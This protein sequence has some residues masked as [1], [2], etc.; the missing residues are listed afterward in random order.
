MPLVI[1]SIGGTAI[2]GSDLE[3]LNGFPEILNLTV[4]GSQASAVGG[5]HIAQLKGITNFTITDGEGMNSDF[6]Q[7]M[8][9]LESLRFDKAGEDADIENLKDLPKLSFLQ[10]Q[11]AR[12]TDAAL[13]RFRQLPALS[14]LSLTYCP[15]LTDE[16]LRHLHELKQLTSLDLA[17]NKGLTA[18]GIKELTAALP[19]CRIESDHGTFGPPA[20]AMTPDR[21]AAAV[22]LE[23]GGTVTVRLASGETLPVKALAELPTTPFFVTDIILGNLESVDDDSLTHFR[24]LSG[25]LGLNLAN[26][27][28]TDRG[29][30]NLTNEGRQPLP[31]LLRLYLDGTYVSQD[32]LKYLSGSRD[33]QGLLLAESAIT[34]G[35]VLGQFPK[36]SMLSVA[37]TS[38]KTNELRVIR[39]LP[40][41]GNLSIDARHFSGETATDIASLSRLH[42]LMLSDAN[43]FD[44]SILSRLESLKVLKVRKCAADAIDGAFWK[45]VAGLRGLENLSFSD[46]TDQSLAEVSSM[47]QLRRFEV[48]SRSVSGAALVKA[49][50][51]FPN[52]TSLTVTYSEWSDDDVQQLHGLKS[53]RELNLAGNKASAEAIKSL[54]AA[55]PDCRIISDHGTFG[56]PAAAMSPDRHAAEV[57]LELGGSVSVRM[58]S[59]ETLPIKAPTGLPT[60][61]FVVTDIFLG[62]LESVDDDSLTHF[63]GLNDLLGLSLVNDS[64]TDRG[65]ANLTDEGRQPLPAL[66]RLY[67]DGTDVSQDGL[68][69]LSG[70]QELQGLLIAE[71]AITSGDVLGQFPKLMMLGLS[72]TSLETNELQVVCKL[73]QLG[74]LY[75][76]ARHL[77]G[78]TATDI[79]GLPGLK[80]LVVH[81]ASSR[82]DASALARMESLKSLVLHSSDPEAIDGAFWKSVEG[83]S[84]LETLTFTYGVTDQSLAVVSSMPQLREFTVT[85]K[86]V[87]GAAV[88]KA[89]MKFPKVTSLTVNFSDLSDDDVRQLHGLK[90]LRHLNLPGNKASA[91]AIKAL[92]AALPTCRIISDH[93]TFGLPA[94]AMSPDRRGAEWVLSIGGSIGIDMPDGTRLEV[95]DRKDLP[96]GLFVVRVVEVQKLPQ[97]TD[98][99]L[100]N[101]R[102]CSQLGAF[103]AYDTEI[104]DQGLANL[105][106]EGRQPLENLATLFIARTKVSDT[107]LQYLAGSKELLYLDIQSNPVSDGSLLGNYRQLSTLDI[108]RS[109]I[110]AE[111]LSILQ[112]LPLLRKLSVDGRQLEGVGSQHVSS[113]NKLSELI[114]QYPWQGFDGAVLRELEGLTK[115]GLL[116]LPEGQ[117]ENILWAAVASVPTLENLHLYGD[118]VTD[119]SIGK[120]PALPELKVLTLR[121][122]EEKFSGETIAA[123]VRFA[124]AL[125]ELVVSHDELN[126]G[127]AKSLESLTQLTRLTVTDN[128]ITAAAIESLRK[129]LPNCRIISDHGTFK[130]AVAAMRPDRRAAEAALKLG[131][132]VVVRDAAGSMVSITDSGKLPA[133]PFVVTKIDLSEKKNIEDEFLANFRGLKKLEILI[134]TETSVTDRGLANLTDEGRQPLPSL[135]RLDLDGTKISQTGLKFLSGS[136][137]LWELLL[138][139][140]AISQSPVLGQFPNLTVFDIADTSLTSDDLQIIAEFSNLERLT[141]DASRLTETVTRTVADLSKLRALKLRNLPSDF[142]SGQLAKFSLLTELYVNADDHEV[143]DDEFWLAIAGL[144]ELHI[145]MCKGVTDESLAKAQA[146]PQVEVLIVMSRVVTGEAFVKSM[147]NFP[148]VKSLTVNYTDWT[149]DDVQQLHGLKSLGKLDLTKNSASVEA[150]KRLSAALPKCQIISDHGTFE[151]SAGAMTPDLRTAQWVV[152]N[153]GSC[154]IRSE[155]QEQGLVITTPEAIPDGPFRLVEI[156]LSKDGIPEEEFVRLSGLTSLETASLTDCPL[157]DMGLANLRDSRQLMSLSLGNTQVTDDG[158]AV[159]DSFPQLKELTLPNEITDKGYVHVLKC[160]RLEQLGGSF[161]AIGGPSLNRLPELDQLQMLYIY[162]VDA[163]STATDASRLE[164]FHQLPELTVLHLFRSKLSRSVI[165]AL[166]QARQI[167]TLSLFHCEIESGGLAELERLRHLENLSLAGS[168]LSDEHVEVLSKLTGLDALGVSDNDFTSA[169]ISRLRKGLPEC[170]VVSDHGT[171]EPAS[172]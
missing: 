134:L 41:M 165:K 12:I 27:S 151:P 128:D 120:M 68:Q 150:I 64:I 25:L 7:K 63:R 111:E 39:K 140:T 93:G 38:L 6:I 53:L 130:P 89:M 95:E 90:S 114:V 34:R 97:V 123:A 31:T 40:Q 61:P 59:G 98:D 104:T 172:K 67:L 58:A 116:E 29:L 3:L 101:L 85:S 166:G 145:L 121:N 54:S 139:G 35:D 71:T 112:G 157:T 131:G 108:V 147:S 77:S 91:E 84:E 43:G 55:L 82:F 144:Q 10:L 103:F 17:S 15:E 156:T 50:S 169:G 23:L 51:K 33:L 153:G 57:V 52:V 161:R 20:V 106:D 9:G 47:P 168:G 32:G 142:E 154:V 26:D 46:V 115:L 105:T 127:D 141:M 18:D 86:S 122:G 74:V 119:A 16:G 124:P 66:L 99:G 60:A 136:H 152:A 159:L 88:A 100:I 8:A 155:G 24:G 21:R 14:R 138:N 5:Q 135:Q 4:D 109:K 125:Q 83:L 65:L 94:A 163:S 19:G 110:S 30:A 44:S 133:E 148:N 73:P 2:K 162:G 102:G 167:R 42:T 13:S 87:S 171:F 117:L 92:S 149:D 146:A 69:F 37:R 28:I 170:K 113:L 80:D 70:S 56:P 45:S 79:A 118:G 72:K 22:V 96:D 132:S 107:G 75:I 1:L 158:L 143:F 160:K 164:V 81:G 126:D 48:T 78:E 11:Y 76:D 36:L 49:M 129:A 137:A 62:N